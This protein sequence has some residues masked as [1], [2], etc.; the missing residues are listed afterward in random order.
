MKSMSW[1]LN[2]ATKIHGHEDK[3]GRLWSG[4]YK[5]YPSQSEADLALCRLLAFY[6]NCDAGEIDRLFRESGL[7]RPKW[8]E[9]HFAGGKTYGQA[10]IEK[11][12]SSADERYARHGQSSNRAAGQREFNLTDL[13]NAERLV[14]HFGDRIRYCHAWKKWLIWDGVRWVV[15]HTDQIRQ[16]AKKVIRKIYR[17]AEAVSDPSKR[18]AIAKHAMSS[19]S[20]KRIRAMIALAESE[21]PITPEELDRDPWLLTCL[22]GTLDL[23]TNTLHAPSQ[24]G[25]HHEACL[26]RL[27]LE[28]GKPALARFS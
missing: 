23:R 17:E 6:T 15:D 8:D 4:D 16:L 14:H 1:A 28:G 22:N 24:G 19:E 12:V 20:D 27:R 10:T 18:Q 21:L 26:G 3:I 11:A 9:P 13:G 25:F 2:P 7:Y 5:D